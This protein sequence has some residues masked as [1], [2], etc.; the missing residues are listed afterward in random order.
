MQN[1]G[2]LN[3][4]LVYVKLGTFVIDKQQV[5][6]HVLQNVSYVINCTGHNTRLDR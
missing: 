6:L 3:C 1:V 2:T 4:D 5:S